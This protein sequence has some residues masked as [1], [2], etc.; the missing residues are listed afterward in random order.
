MDRFYF[1]SPEFWKDLSE[2]LSDL[3]KLIFGG[4]KWRSFV[5]N[6]PYYCR[7]KCEYLDECRSYR[8]GW[9][10]IQ[11]CAFYVVWDEKKIEIEQ[12]RNE[13]YEAE[14]KKKKRLGRK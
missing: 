6:V 13:L 10:T 5:R 2:G 1:Y 14:L 9:R 12:Q 3:F 4:K 8:K 7:H 11:G